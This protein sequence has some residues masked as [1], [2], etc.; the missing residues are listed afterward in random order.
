MPRFEPI[1]RNV[2]ISRE[3]MAKLLAMPLDEMDAWSPVYVQVLDPWRA[4]M[5]AMAQIMVD[6]IKAN[7][8]AGRITTLILPVG[9]QSSTPRSRDL[10]PRTGVVEERLD[11]QHGRVSDWEGRPIE[12]HHVVPRPCSATCSTA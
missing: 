1:V 4:V 3:D 5:E 8:A 6:C 11:L 2:T 9:P 12:D 7:N 10:E